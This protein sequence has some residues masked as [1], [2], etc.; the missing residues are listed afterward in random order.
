METIV[1]G[2]TCGTGNDRCTACCK[3]LEISVRDFSKPAGAWCPHCDLGRKMCRIYPYRP[4]TCRTFRCEWLKGWGDA[5]ERPDRTQLIFD[6]H[7]EG[8]FADGLLQVFEV[9]EGALEGDFAIQKTRE[10]TGYGTPVLYLPLHGRKR[11]F[12]PP[13]D[14]LEADIIAALEKEDIDIGVLASA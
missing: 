12:F 10:V 2:R 6:F 3:S 13:H 4:P 7:K 11:L 9:S 1:P 14:I 8:F 5:D